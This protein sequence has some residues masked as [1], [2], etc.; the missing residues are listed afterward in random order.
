MFDRNV[1]GHPGDVTLKSGKGVNNLEADALR[2]AK[3]SQIPVPHAPSVGKKTAEGKNHLRVDL[4][5]GQ[6]LKE[7]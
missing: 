3:L 7:L 5:E 2:T 4:I 1:T 6:T